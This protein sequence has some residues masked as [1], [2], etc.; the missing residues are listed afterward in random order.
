MQEALK[1]VEAL[2]SKLQRWELRR[3]LG[4]PHD[5]SGAVLTVL[6]GAGGWGSSRVAVAGAAWSK[7]RQQGSASVCFGIDHEQS[8]M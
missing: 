3:L 1:G 5:E 4:G 6:S 8:H 2:E 7:G